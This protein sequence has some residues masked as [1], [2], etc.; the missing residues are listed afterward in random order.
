VKEEGPLAKLRNEGAKRAKGDIL[1]FTDD[2]II[3]SPK[4]LSAINKEFEDKQDIGGVS[5]PSFIS[6]EFRRNRDIFKFKFFKSVYDKFFCDGLSHLPGHITKSG[7]WTTGACDEKCDYQGEVEFLEA[8]NMA[9]RADIFYAIGGFDESYLGVG[10]WSE[11]DLSFR[12]RRAG[13]H[14][15]F[16]R[17]ARIEHQPS[18]SGAYKKRAGDRSRLTNYEKFAFKWI[19]PNFKHTLYK[20]F[21]RIYYAFKAIK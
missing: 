7:A 16:S 19:K 17:D 18:K 3:A 5:G 1:V 21:L 4:W 12:V 2:D 8:C 9:F 13:Y 15:W 10:D 14:L 11:P 20:L 6:R